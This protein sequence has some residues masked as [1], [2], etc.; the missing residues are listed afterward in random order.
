MW[1]PLGVG[2][3]KLAHLRQNR[4]AAPLRLVGDIGATNA[5]FGLLAAGEHLPAR[6]RSFACAD[7][8]GLEAAIRHY[9]ALEGDARPSDAVLCVANPVHGEQLEMTNRDWSIAL[10]ELRGALGLDCLQAINDFSALALALPE[11]KAGELRKIGGGAAQPGSALA[12]LGPG[13]GLGVSGLL[14]CGDHW[15]PLAGEGGHITMP[16][17][18]AREGEVLARIRRRHGHASAERVLSGPGL[19]NLHDALRE[20]DHLPA[21]ERSPAEISTLGITGEC[22]RCTEALELFCAMLGTVAADLVLTLGARGG[23]FIGGGIVPQLGEFFAHSSFRARFEDKGRFSAYLAAVPSQV[24]HAPHAAL[25]GAA[26]AA[27][28]PH[29]IGCTVFAPEA[30]ADAGTA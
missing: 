3:S 18:S 16:A 27:E 20:I 24:I 12:V 29:D 14:P 9:L 2:G 22:R 17:S 30:G 19:V 26:R 1:F 15:L 25:T 6:V 23:V 8:D 13:S 7:F 4:R 21:L 28:L 11:L 10:P 5:R